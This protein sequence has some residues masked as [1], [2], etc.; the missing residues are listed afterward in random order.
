MDKKN[1]IIGSLC[2]FAAFWLFVSQSKSIEQSAA[3]TTANTAQVANAAQETPSAAHTAPV[4][5]CTLFSMPA[6]QKD[7]KCVVLENNALKLC[8]S[9]LT[10]GIQSAELKQFPLS[11]EQA[12]P[13]V[14]NQ[15]A[16]LPALTL[17]FDPQGTPLTTFKVTAQTANSIQLDTTLSDGTQIVRVYRLP[18]S[19]AENP[20][21]I[22]TDIMVRQP[23]SANASLT[24]KGI[25]V[26]LGRMLG[27]ESDPQQEYLNFCAYDGSKTEFQRIAE[28]EASN[29]LLGLGKHE[30]HPYL[31]DTK[32]FVW[33]ALKNQFFAAIL[34][35][36][37]PASRY[38]SFPSK[39]AEQSYLNGFLELPLTQSNHKLS[40][41]Y[42]V[43][44]KQYLLLEKMGK[45]QDELMQFG[46]FSAVS[47]VLLMSMHA[48]HHVVPNWGW[49]ILILT[50]I[51]KV[52]MWPITQM[53]LNSSKK[54]GS[55]QEP[56]KK[57]KE[58]YKSNPQKLQEETMKLFK[59]NRIN[60][61]SGCLPLL[62]Q[63]PIFIG[64]YCVLRSASEIRFQS[65]L[66]IKDLSMPD[67]IC[68]L[69]SFPLNIMPLIMGVT[70][71]VQMKMTP[72]PTAD[73]SQQKMLLLMPFI[74][75]F[76]CYGFPSALVL[77]WTAQNVFTILQQLLTNRN[78]KTA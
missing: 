24:H 32:S 29:G 2:L 40:A 46:L 30:A 51:I 5:N 70:M 19:D 6:N 20:Y 66:W 76:F 55:I 38:I 12:T 31:E 33:G 9:T 35:P 34:T 57:I 41:T 42:Y 37:T 69:G 3:V 4:S 73:G 13:Y 48:I 63:I 8:F 71:L 15:G 65:F 25:W 14:F 64:L 21:L 27:S 43:G 49:V 58:K 52:L 17:S 10:G 53:Q 68:M 44:P 59:E 47:K 7:S 23:E 50:V 60:P 78:K 36:Q 67:T 18:E 1:L 22:Q 75:L 28:F 16:P 39:D 54:M 45:N 77:Y 62:I 74:F 56:L 61:A 11:Q 26:S 72:T